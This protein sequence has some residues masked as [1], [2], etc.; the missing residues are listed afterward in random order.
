[1]W[2]AAWGQALSRKIQYLL[3]EEKHQFVTQYFMKCAVYGHTPIL[4]M[5]TCEYQNSASVTLPTAT[6]DLTYFKKGTQVLP[7]HTL[8]FILWLLLV[9]PCFIIKDN[10]T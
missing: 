7:F 3:T 10:V 4:T 2:A 5:P 8:T 9:N 6:S 1:M